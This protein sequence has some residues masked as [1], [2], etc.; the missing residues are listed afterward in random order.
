MR[1]LSA[2]AAVADDPVVV[3]GADRLLRGADLWLARRVDGHGPGRHRS[4]RLGEGLELADIREYTPGDDVRTIDWNV[5]AR[6]GRP[7]VRVYDAD[8]DVTV[9]V[10]AD[11][12]ASMGFG[13][14]NATKD[15]LARELVAAV[16]AMVVRRGDR[17]GGLLFD[18]ERAGG[19]RAASG[20]RAALRLLHA[21]EAAPP[22]DRTAARMDLALTDAGRMA[23]RR[24]VVLAISDWI[25]AGAWEEPLRL[26]AYRHEVIA[27]EIRD[28]REDTLPDVG[29]VVLEDPETGRQLE[30]D[31]GI[32][33][34]REAFETAAAQQRAA[35]AASF[36]RARASHLIVSTDRDWRADLIKYLT[37]RKKGRR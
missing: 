27:A 14:A 4:I 11:R 3:P 35:R 10:V 34:L 18:E 30:V 8:R 6:T 7:H 21:M 13:T 36:A 32:A 29:T 1:H 22:K 20:R 23:K 15:R 26:L 25:D 17:I 19:M 37:L 12:S 24:S 9:L 31:T 33:G 5:T 16:A 28:P 2:V